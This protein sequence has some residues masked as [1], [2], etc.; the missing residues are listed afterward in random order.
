MSS[1][2]N[3]KLPWHTD[4]HLVRQESA[5]A[6]VTGDATTDVDDGHANGTN[7]LLRVAHDPHLEDDGHHQ[8]N[9]PA[10]SPL[11]KPTTSYFADY[12]EPI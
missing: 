6:K 5:A 3:C 1:K 9:Q 2:A 12:L 10:S 4:L 11:K 7:Q 8:V